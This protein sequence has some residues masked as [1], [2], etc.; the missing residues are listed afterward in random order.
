MSGRR[1]FACRLLP[2]L[3]LL[4]GEQSQ[5]EKVQ[6][7]SSGATSSMLFDDEFTDVVPEET[8]AELEEGQDAR[9][10]CC[11]GTAA[12]DQ[13]TTNITDHETS[14]AGQGGA[15]LDP[16]PAVPST[17][18]PSPVPN[19]STKNST[20][21]QHQELGQHPTR[22][23]PAPTKSTAQHQHQEE[24]QEQDSQTRTR[25]RTRT[26][27][28]AAGRARHQEQQDDTQHQSGK[29][30]EAKKKRKR[31]E[32]E[33]ETDEQDKAREDGV[34]GQRNS[35]LCIGNS[36]TYTIFHVLQD[37]FTQGRTGLSFQRITK[38]GCKMD[39]HKNSLQQGDVHYRNTLSAKKWKYVVLQEAGYMPWRH[40]YKSRTFDTSLKAVLWWD[41]KIEE[42]GAET[43]VYE[44]IYRRDGTRGMM[45][46]QR[47]LG[48]KAFARAT[49]KGVDQYVKALK[50]KGRKPKYAPVGTAFLLAHMK[51]KRL[52]HGLYDRDGTHPSHRGQYLAS[53]VLFATISGDS[54]KS[55]HLPKVAS[56]YRHYADWEKN[57]LKPA[58]ITAEDG[59]TLREIAHKAVFG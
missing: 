12:T 51:D 32:A 55:L 47:K 46:T 41:K 56:S 21:E 23:A 38:G 13:Q 58:A 15:V 45:S 34:E 5:A 22:P 26:R 48:F 30:S 2:L 27:T 18:D 50:K 44:P 43:V 6:V 57:V 7:Y 35:V 29:S 1:L 53:C 10:D 19:T 3:P 39:T 36:L 17:Q 9:A 52:W 33:D 31:G 24:E 4:G 54:P 11:G 16:A 49:K 59:A 14:L 25:S 37:A 42:L 8:L 28:R 40:S 20:Y